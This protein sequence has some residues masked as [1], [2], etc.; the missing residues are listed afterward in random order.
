MCFTSILTLALPS[1]SLA[2]A[3]PTPSPDVSKRDI[4]PANINAI[5]NAKIPDPIA[6]AMLLATNDGAKQP[7]GPLVPLEV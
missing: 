2:L 1:P 6:V 3:A 4:I 7:G 5:A